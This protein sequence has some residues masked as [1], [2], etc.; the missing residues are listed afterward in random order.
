MRLDMEP[1]WEDNVLA[2]VDGLFANRLGPAIEADAKR[3]AP[4]DTGALRDS[5]GHHLE[6]HDLIVDAT[7]DYAAY[8]EMGHRVAHGP[9]MQEVGPKVVPPRPYLRPALY[10]GRDE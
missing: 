10:Q 3:Y 8:V 1:G 5:I 2:A 7:V 6:G 4:V 9:R